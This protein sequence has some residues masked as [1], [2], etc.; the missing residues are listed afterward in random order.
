MAYQKPLPRLNSDSQPFW[1]ACRKHRLQFQR[2][3]DCGSLRWP[4]AFICPECHSSDS[5]W[6]QVSGRGRIVTYAV[7]HRAYRKEFKDDLPY[8]TAVIELD[9][10]VRM[11]SNVV[12]CD[13]AQLACDMRVDLVWEDVT[14]EFSLP[15][16]RLVDGR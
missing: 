4:P 11:L 13:P 6:V 10:G 7:I 3:R 15:K 5:Q 2:C 1:D 16:F 12:G 14:E 8:V 9:E